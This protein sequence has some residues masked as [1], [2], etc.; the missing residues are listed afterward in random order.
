M[1]YSTIST[2]VLFVVMLGGMGAKAIWDETGG[3]QGRWPTW[4]KLFRP[5]LVS[6]IAF[7]AFWGP[8]YVQQD[9]RGLSLTMA[10]Y[11]F[12]IWFMWQHVLEKKV[13]GH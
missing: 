2:L 1:E 9:G 8:M 10:L 11:A 7:A 4:N 13:G 6:P 12:Q 5:F 3:D